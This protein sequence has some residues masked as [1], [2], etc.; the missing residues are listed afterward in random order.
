[1]PYIMQFFLSITGGDIGASWRL[2]MIVPV[3][4][5]LSAALLIQSGRDL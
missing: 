2:C 4:M 1:M 3:V 5:H